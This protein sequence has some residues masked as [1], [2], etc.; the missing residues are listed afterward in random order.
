MINAQNDD[1]LDEVENNLMKKFKDLG[2]E[3]FNMKS[4]IMSN[5]MEIINNN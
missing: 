1:D 5:D 2:N 3:V 4:G